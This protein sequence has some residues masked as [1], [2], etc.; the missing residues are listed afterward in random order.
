MLVWYVRLLLGLLLLLVVVIIKFR[1]SAYGLLG[2]D[3]TVGL[4]TF[5][6]WSTT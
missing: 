6:L 4:M 2:D 5:E 3:S 1:V